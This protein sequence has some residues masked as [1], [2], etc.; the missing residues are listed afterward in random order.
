MDIR[1]L[2]GSVRVPTLV[3]HRTGDRADVEA[4]RYM[5]ARLPHARFVELPGEDHLP[6][7]GDQE[8]ILAL[9]QE[10]LTGTPRAVDTNRAVLTVMFTDIVGSTALA[11]R[12]GD[13][14]WRLLLEEH[15][16]VMR[17]IVARFGGQEID[18][19]GDGFLITFDG[20]ARAIRAAAAARSGTRRSGHPH[21]GGPAHRRMSSWSGTKFGASPCTSP[22]AS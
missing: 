13:R 7:A 22:L 15:D 2:L 20:P 19:A 1:E 16:Q 12:L 10:F 6:F 4:S 5:A 8:T 21:P 14:R 17:S 18:N 3:L 11:S 9:T